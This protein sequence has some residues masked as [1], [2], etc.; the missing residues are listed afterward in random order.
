MHVALRFISLILIVAGLML[1]GSDFVTS[2]E[3]GALQ[4]RSIDQIWLLA[5]KS[6]DLAFHAWLARTLPAAL[7][8]GME[9]VLSLWAF[10]LPGILGVFLAILFGRKT[11]DE[12]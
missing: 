8:R 2:L 5:S 3:K 4:A 11:V 12:S 1:L 7:A 10:A 6:S 9:S